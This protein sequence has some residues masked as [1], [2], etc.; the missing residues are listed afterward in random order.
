MLLTDSDLTLLEVDTLYS[1]CILLRLPL[2]TDFVPS[3]SVSKSFIAPS[4]VSAP[5]VIVIS[6]G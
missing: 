1:R 6:W 2:G 5:V 4:V 3:D